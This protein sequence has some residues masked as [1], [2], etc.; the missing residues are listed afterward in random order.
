PRGVFSGELGE[1]DDNIRVIIDKL[2][3]K[4]GEPKERLNVMDPMWFGPVMDGL[5][6]V[7]R[8]GEPF[9]VELAFFRLG[10]EAMA[11]QPTEDLFHMLAVD[12]YT[13][14]KHVSKDTVDKLLE[15][16]WWLSETKR[17]D[18]PLI[19]PI[20]G[21]KSGL[22]FITI[23]DVDEV[24]GMV[25]VN[26]GVNLC[27]AWGTKKVGDQWQQVVVLLSDLVKALEINTEL[28]GAILLFYK[29]DRGTVSRGRLFDEPVAKVLINESQ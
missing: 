10:I 13:D 11:V 7:G 8:H 22:P 24:V 12:H 27:M 4:I 2:L 21:V 15:G 18:S 14:V 16:S 20:A 1:W 19:G 9:S 5:N 28:E 25:E 3:V 17:H 23:G 29:K 26:F 6:L